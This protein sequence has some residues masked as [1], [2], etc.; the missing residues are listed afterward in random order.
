MF[1][2]GPE[3]FAVLALV[4]VVVFGPDKLPQMAKQAAQMIRTLRDMSTNARQQLSELSPGLGESLGELNSIAKGVGGLGGLG[5][6]SAKSALQKMIFDGDEDPL[7]LAAVRE[8]RAGSTVDPQAVAR[9]ATPIGS[10]G[11][12]AGTTPTL[13]KASPASP[14][15]APASL[16]KA[17]PPAAQAVP[18]DKAAGTD[19]PAPMAPPASPATDDIT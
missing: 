15:A 14:A 12:S 19:E 17:A 5:G 7:G 13:E 11:A 10:D 4:A 9:N 3:E 16:D 2:I 18:L 1:N 6:M 8:D